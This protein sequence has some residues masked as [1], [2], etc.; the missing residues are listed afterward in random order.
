MPWEVEQLRFGCFPCS[1]KF[2]VTTVTIG[3][4]PHAGDFYVRYLPLRPTVGTAESHPGREAGVGA[5]KTEEMERK[6][7]P[8]TRTVLLEHWQVETGAAQPE[9]CRACA[10]T[11]RV[12]CLVAAWVETCTCSMVG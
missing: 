4:V 11:V 12:D 5:G 2:E 7:P 3:K 9:R 8:A 10:L 6:K 1:G